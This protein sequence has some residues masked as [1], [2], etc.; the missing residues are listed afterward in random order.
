MANEWKT[1]KWFVSPWNFNNEV[2]DE[3]SFPDEIKIHDLSLRDGEQQAGITF[4][5]DDKIRIAEKLAEVGVPRIEA[6]M[7]AVSEED[8]KALKKIVK[9]NLEAEIF[10]FSR[11][12]KDDVKRALDCE[13]DGIVIEIPSSE[14]II[15]KAYQWPLQKAIDL[16]V[17]ATSFAKEND[18]YTAFFP[19]DAS[20]ADFEWVMD[21]IEQVATEGHMDS[22]AVVDTFGG[23]SPHSIPYFIKRIK[24]RIDKPLET[25][26]HD[27][28]GMGVANTILG[29]AAGASVAQTSVTAIGERSGNASYEDVALALLT[30]Y[31]IDLGLNFEKI[32]ETSKLIQELAKIKVPTNRSVVGDRI[33]DIESGIIANWFKNCGEE[34]AL[35]LFPFRWD[36]VGQKYPEIV[37]GKGSGLANLNIWL[38]ELDVQNATL[39]EEEKRELLGVVKQKAASKKNL[40]TK[41]EF[42]DLVQ[43]FT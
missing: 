6:G 25:H 35:E 22:L 8:E 31:G 2:V 10:A 42:K 30:M 13:V 17:E 32:Y 14:H 41:D 38:D 33:F 34:N 40:L 4:T 26:F 9:M 11:C 21:L 43:K 29:L 18:L 1:D 12:M 36:L 27:D 28:F 15:Q 24:E 23:C 37:L 20:R 16:S 19:I 39:S 3:L 5:A 7:P